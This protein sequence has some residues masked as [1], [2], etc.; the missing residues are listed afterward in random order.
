MFALYLKI[1]KNM[2]NFF[3]SRRKVIAHCERNAPVFWIMHE[4]ENQPDF[5][6]VDFLDTDNQLLES[7]KLYLQTALQEIEKV[8][9]EWVFK[10]C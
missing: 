4:I 3:N 2:L 1:P 9:Q 5:V 10:I 6:Q 8:R 7:K